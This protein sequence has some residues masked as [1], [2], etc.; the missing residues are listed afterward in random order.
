MSN[1]QVG[2]L[3]VFLSAASFSFSSVVAKWA[4][5]RGFTPF[6]FSLGASIIAV[7]CLGLGLRR[8]RWR[9]PAGVGALA[10]TLFCLTGALSGLLFNLSLSYLDI[11][12]T[13]LLVFTFPA[14][15]T[16]G[17]WVWFGQRPG[18]VQAA[19]IALTLA[20]AAL[21]AGPV[22]GD[23][24]LLGVLAAL[25]TTVTHAL[26]MLLGERLVTRWDP[27]AATAFVRAANA[28]IIAAVAPGA[29]VALVHTDLAGWGFLLLGAAVA[30]V[31]PF[32]FLLWG[33]LKVGASR[34]AIVSAAELPL[35][36]LL[37]RL[38]MDDTLTAAQGV[39]AVLIMAAVVLITWPRRE[40]EAASGR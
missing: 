1:I 38:F 9:P 15:V 32:L 4:F 18:P 29:V 26:Y 10:V 17:A 11:S 7:L 25:G 6:S 39:G 5:A 16:L 40:A 21:T 37:G 31:A 24:H 14:V 12:L 19:A 13:T 8:G 34:A 3:F 27:T 35:A 2:Y 33:I 28:L 23:I 30:A 36:L 22:R 20:G